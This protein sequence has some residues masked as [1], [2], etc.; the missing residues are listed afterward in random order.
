[1]VIVMA[2]IGLVRVCAQRVN[3]HHHTYKE[4]ELVRIAMT[5]LLGDVVD[6][7][8]M[9]IVILARVSRERSAVPTFGVP[10]RHASIRR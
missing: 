10:A 7:P 9:L 3:Q 1:M 5:Q 2:F 8:L 6:V 4:Q